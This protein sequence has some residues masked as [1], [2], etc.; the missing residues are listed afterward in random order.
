MNKKMIKITKSE[1]ETLV[2]LIESYIF[3]IIREDTGIDSI[4]WLD[5]MM[6]IYRKCNTSE[7]KNEE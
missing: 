1:A 6:S 7:F 5:N 3:E 4:Q 2:D